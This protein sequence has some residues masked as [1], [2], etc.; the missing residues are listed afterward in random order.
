MW[1]EVKDAAE[2]HVQDSLL[3]PTSIWPRMSI[4]TLLRSPGIDSRCHQRDEPTSKDVLGHLRAK[5]ESQFGICVWSFLWLDFFAVIYLERRCGW[6]Q[7]PSEKRLTGWTHSQPS[8][9]GG[10]KG[11]SLLWWPINTKTQLK[12]LSLQILV[13]TLTVAYGWI[14]LWLGVTCSDLFH[15]DS[16][17]GLPSLKKFKNRLFH[18]QNQVSHELTEWNQLLVQTVA[19][20]L[21]R[22]PGCRCQIFSLQLI[23]CS[24]VVD[25]V[26]RR[27]ASWW[28]SPP[29]LR[30][31]D[32]K[33]H[34]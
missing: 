1:V 19:L 17:G 27:N 23:R 21:L 8:V 30:S 16:P 11:P 5:C 34:T 12:P 7:G 3:P 18:W 14:N 32:L 9:S 2:R 6:T 22:K 13:A 15:I 29:C 28:S 25:G 33:G 24:W 10:L 31:Q 20:R 4:V 26:W